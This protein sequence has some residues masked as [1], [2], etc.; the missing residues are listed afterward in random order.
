MIVKENFGPDGTTVMAVTIMYRTKS[1]DPEHGDWYWAKYD[2]DGQ[3]SR[4]NGMAV[5]GKVSMCMECHGH[6]SAAGSDFA[7]SNDRSAEQ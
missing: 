2:P 4:M 1:F 3:V 7:F 5:A 6:A